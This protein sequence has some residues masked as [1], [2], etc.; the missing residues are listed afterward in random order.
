MKTLQTVKHH[1]LILGLIL[2]FSL[3]DTHGQTPATP[4]DCCGAQPL[5][6]ANMNS[7]DA[8]F[9]PN[10]SGFG[11]TKE[12]FLPCQAIC[13][14]EAEIHSWWFSFRC[15]QSGTFEF[16]L[17]PENLPPPFVADYNWT[18]FENDCPCGPNTNL[19]ACND[20]APHGPQ[21]S[22]GN[23]TGIANNVDD[24][25]G[26]LPTTYVP[27]AIGPG[28][29]EATV[30]LI[31]GNDYHLYINNISEFLP[32]AMEL[33]FAGT[34]SISQL[35]DDPVLQP[36]PTIVGNFA[37]CPFGENLVYEAIFPG[38][39][40]GSNE[41]FNWSLTP[42]G[43]PFGNGISEIQVN[44]ND[45]GTYEL[46]VQVFD[47]CL[48]TSQVACET[49]VVADI[50]PT[51]VKD[52]VCI[53]EPYIAGNGQAY[54]APGVFNYTIVTENGCDS[55]VFLELDALE[56]SATSLLE[57]ICEGESVTV[58]GEEY[59][60]AGFY[61]KELTNE[62]GC[63]SVVT[64]FLFVFPFDLEVEP[65]IDT[66]SC[67]DITAVFDTGNSAVDDNSS[68]EWTDIFGTVVDTT[69]V[70][71]TSVSGLYFLKVEDPNGCTGE[72][73]VEVI[74]NFTTPQADAGPFA[75]LSC[76]DDMTQLDGN[77]STQGP[78]VTY[79]WSG[80]G[81]VSGGNT[82][83]P[84][85]NQSGI[86][87]LTVTNIFSGCTEVSDVEVL[88]DKEPP[89]ADAGPESNLDCTTTA[90]TL[91]GSASDQG[92]Q[93]TYAWTGPGIQS[94]FNTLNPVV[95]QSGFYTIVVTNEDNGCT[96]EASV[97]VGLDDTPPDVNAGPGQQL[98][99]D[100]ESVMLEGSTVAGSTY[101]WS[102]PLILNGVNTLTPEVG[103]PGIYTLTVATAGGCSA[104]A[105]VSVEQDLTPPVVDPG[106]A[107]NLN[108]N[109]DDLI[110]DGS[111]SSQGSN[112]IY[113]W[114]GPGIV[115]GGN[116]LTPTIN[117]LGEYEL[118]ITNTD[119]GCTE[120]ASIEI[121]ETPPPVLSLLSQEN[122]D[123]NGNATGSATVEVTDGQSPYTYDWSSGGTDATET[124]LTSG[125]F[126][127]TVTDD[128]GC[129]ATL[130]V[131]INEPPVL[132]ISIAS[133][134]LT[135][136]GAND[137]TATANPNGGTSPYAYN[138][139]N[140]ATTQS[141]DNL[142]PGAYSVTVTDENGC[143]SVQSVTIQDFDCSPVSLNFDA[144]NVDCNG[145]ENGAATA[146]VTNGA[147]PV[148]YAWSNGG[149][150]ETINDLS[151]GNYTVTITDDNGCALIDEVTIT[152][153]TAL[154]GNIL[155]F[156]NVDCNGNA[157]GSASVEVSGGTP[158][159]AYEWSS[160][161]TI[162]D[163]TGLP[164]G[165]HTVTI[166][167]AN[168]CETTLQVTITEPPV[169]VLD[170]DGT[171]ETGVDKNDGT[172][173]ATPSGGT[174]DYTYLW[175]NDEVDATISD[176]A[177]GEY[178]VTI[179]DAN[180][181]TTEDCF[182]VNEFECGI[183]TPEFD[184]VE[185]NCNNG[186]DGEATVNI[187]GGTAPFSY[188]W[189]NGNTGETAT[190]LV[191]S[192]YEVTATDVNGCVIVESISIP[193]PAA[194]QISILNITDAA[195]EGSASGSASVDAMGGTGNLAYEWSNGSM[196][197]MIE[198]VVPGTYDVSVTDEN[199]CVEIIEVIIGGEN[200]AEPPIVLVQNIWVVLDNNGM[201][202]ISP[203]MVDNG[204]SDN[205]E[206]GLLSLD[207]QNFTCDD[208]GDVTVT[209]TASDVSGNT[210]SETAVVT[211]VDLT[212]PT[213]TCPDDIFSNFCLFPVNYPA[214]TAT[215][216]CGDV[217]IELV[218]GL[219]PGSIFPLGTTAVIYSAT[220]AS[221]NQSD[222]TFNIT[223]LTD[224]VAETEIA[225]P[226]CFGDTNGSATV[227]VDNGTPPYNYQ[228]NDPDMQATPT[229]TDLPAGFYSV[230]ITDATGCEIAATTEVTEPDT[231]TV[232]ID[233]ANPDCAGDDNGTATAIPNGGTGPF[234]YQW[235]D[236]AMQ[237]SETA[238]NLAPNDYEVLVT[239]NNGCETTANVQI[240]DPEAVV[241]TIDNVTD[242]TGDN[243]DGAISITPSGGT[244]TTYTYEWTY[245]GNPFS[246]EED[247][248][249]LDNGEYCVTVTD[250]N[251][252]T[253]TDCAVVDFIEN[254]INPELDN[255]ITIT[256]NP[257]SGELNVQLKLPGQ[258][259]V[260]IDFYDVL[261]R[262]IL[263]GETYLTQ[264]QQMI[265]DL[266]S[267]A[268]GVYLLKLIV[269]EEILV[270][271]IIK[272]D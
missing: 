150:T 215:D 153:P 232:S 229:A 202:S 79:E 12:G 98:D 135:K 165:M 177:P 225:E 196:E 239:D 162:A 190:G 216:N 63:D 210:A 48:P 164:A 188:E 82:T 85:V 197:M 143:T 144:A 137:G 174:S 156:E 20:L 77:G 100:T 27:P 69:P 168:D 99:C 272:E 51:F 14:P 248:T 21:N 171:G 214:P 96:A 43:P 29:F 226:D 240:E 86:Y 83:T 136:V 107:M 151:A 101:S 271:R 108:C 233:F 93:Y 49:I 110:L 259:N 160:G 120:S 253:E 170:V 140:G 262:L 264:E 263:K 204:S 209:L 166:T 254:T 76:K 11:I 91:D 141:V 178:C 175:S 230:T 9:V 130:S 222:C 149:D 212:V 217:T 139:E 246:T 247:L 118:L 169:L 119:N 206:L 17:D 55:T 73:E 75:T 8:V 250:E 67:K 56:P 53:G 227:D 81:I 270:K 71:E 36:P 167:D 54:F 117:A 258:R 114:T 30:T 94:G 176:L 234:N 102:G 116:S 269:D 155:G 112:F 145:E 236:P 183:I 213:M 39:G 245:N 6:N 265:F 28:P 193:E 123:C 154:K 106:P 42:S 267:Y 194:I 148:T 92:F 252:C 3:N 66:I 244:N 61:V 97:F 268:D 228:W 192:T 133:T 127:V 80:P 129:T 95:V 57:E 211:V 249:N 64:L 201:A 47:G 235:N 146:V 52:S 87:F 35:H 242:E 237:T 161:G 147:N 68:F 22:G 70:F 128:Q 90:V 41:T 158:D 184:V 115:S 62:A 111:N 113:A 142:A 18:L 40:I 23:W 257:T 32:S 45:L 180:G 1:F 255:Y 172:A 50:P 203:D 185:V 59:T 7:I 121:T 25:F 58:G 224:M 4:S 5:T 10:F 256:P 126:S 218:E 134:D 84:T 163:E 221:G 152:E 186:D 89:E 231:L 33:Y 179:T 181:C 125:D 243:M 78:S 189:S 31:E 187:T 13:K 260:R 24:S 131:S 159:Y 19:I 74:E 266:S 60:E 104:S 109:A 223:V 37:P 34:A 219:E 205:C 44:W 195:C 15:V 122:V 208:I 157:T 241:I 191:A 38:G 88:D 238:S 65:E 132:D 173:T 26:F 182:T 46:C 199:N 261:G 198:N 124:D 251:G 72:K 2:S 207:I 220:D 16:L 105:V 200:D 103:A 138:W